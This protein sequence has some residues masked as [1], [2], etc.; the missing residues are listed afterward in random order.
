MISIWNILQRQSGYFWCNIHSFCNIQ[1]RNFKYF[2]K[3]ELAERNE[4]LFSKDIV[5]L[6]GPH[7]HRC[8]FIWRSVTLG[9]L[10]A[11]FVEDHVRHHHW[12]FRICLH[13][14]GGTSFL[15]LC[16]LS[17]FESFLFLLLKPSDVFRCDNSAI[18]VHRIVIAHEDIIVT[19]FTKQ[20]FLVII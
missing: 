14:T 2:G 7:H 15:T 12:V 13:L 4:I 10:E 5:L 16:S 3:T 1:S 20:L 19:K 6:P 11:H 17:P 8:I 9:A 18:A